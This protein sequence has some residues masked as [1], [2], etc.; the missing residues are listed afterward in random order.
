MNMH[1]S[2]RVVFS[3]LLALAGTASVVVADDDPPDAPLLPVPD[4][5]RPSP[6]SSE[7]T[8][9][10]ARGACTVAPPKANAGPVPFLPGENLHFDVNVLGMRTGQVVLQANR[11]TRIDNV[12]VMPV[13]A[14]AKTDNA[15]SFFGELEGRM[16]SY[17]DPKD[18]QPVRMVNHVQTKQMFK[19]PAISREDAAFSD[20]GQVASRVTYWRNGK[21][22]SW[23]GKS[24]GSTDLVDALSV[25]YYAR[26]RALVEGEPF[27]FQVYHRRRIWQIEGK[28]GALESVSPPIG[29]RMARRIDVVAKRLGGKA[30]ESTRAITVHLSDDKARLPLIV[31]TIDGYSDIA[32][33]LRNHLAG[34]A[35][36]R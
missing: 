17:V 31:R 6:R 16:L 30:S 1:H 3:L 8:A 22:R 4:L 19:K 33:E 9:K 35:G 15:F 23:P 36:A 13:S 29:K 11:T 25:V 28:M 24:N 27:C 2:P 7:R 34:H 5:L 14:Y 26:T 18:A 20:D 32:L 12:E 21:E 10:V